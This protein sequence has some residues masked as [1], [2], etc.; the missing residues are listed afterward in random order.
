MSWESVSGRIP[1][2]M[3]CP[4]NSAKN[5]GATLIEGAAFAKSEAGDISHTLARLA[6]NPSS[7]PLLAT[8]ARGTVPFGKIGW[9]PGQTLRKN[10]D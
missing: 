10:H 6:L 3:L 5:N 8:M 7:E 9:I 4:F 2:V 1:G